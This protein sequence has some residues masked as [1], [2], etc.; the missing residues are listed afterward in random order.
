[1]GSF[2]LS[3]EAA[4]PPGAVKLFYGSYWH[5]RARENTLSNQGYCSSAGGWPAGTSGFKNTGGR[6]STG[7]PSSIAWPTWQNGFSGGSG[8]SFSSIA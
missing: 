4:S 8:M 7:T 2:F 5:C 1:M 6:S 3:F